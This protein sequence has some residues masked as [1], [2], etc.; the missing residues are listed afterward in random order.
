MLWYWPERVP[1]EQSLWHL[2]CWLMCA[3]VLACGMRRQNNVVSVL[4]RRFASDPTLTVPRLTDG[5]SSECLDTVYLV[6][7]GQRVPSSC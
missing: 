7:I 5:E 6:T 3:L 4:L 2:G 1:P